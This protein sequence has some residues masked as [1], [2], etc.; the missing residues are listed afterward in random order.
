MEPLI[1]AKIRYPKLWKRIEEEFTQRHL[2]K[3]LE[4]YHAGRP[5]L[6]GKLSVSEHVVSLASDPS[7][8]K[9][10]V[11]GACQEIARV[12]VKDDALVIEG[13]EQSNSAPL[14]VPMSQIPNTCLLEMLLHEASGERIACRG[15]S[16]S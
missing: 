1:W 15:L 6:F 16:L 4:S 14:S 12:H 9:T 8:Q 3:A 2:Q 11:W 7:D 13:R 10:L 5:V